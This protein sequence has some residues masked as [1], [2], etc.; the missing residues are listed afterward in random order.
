MNGA[1]ICKFYVKKLNIPNVNNFW[2]YINLLKGGKIDIDKWMAYNNV[3]N[4]SL[5]DY[6]LMTSSDNVSNNDITKYPY[7]K[8]TVTDTTSLFGGK[9]AYLIIS[10]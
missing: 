3:T 9:N 1:T 8:T 6:I 4:I 5:S 7:F 2:E 10:G